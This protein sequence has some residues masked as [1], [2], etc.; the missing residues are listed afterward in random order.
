MVVD[1]A[2]WVG[3]YAFR[4]LGELATPEWLLRQMDRLGIDRAWVG[5]L[6]AAVTRDPRPA[7]AALQRTLSPHAD[8]LVMIP[9]VHPGQARWQ[10]DVRR[11]TDLGAPAIRLYP[12]YLEL[13]A[14]GAEMRACV[15]AAATAKL[16]VQLTVRLEDM[17][18]RH[19]PDPGT[20]LSAAAVRRLVRAVS[21]SR[22]LVTHATRE[23]VEEVHFGLTPDEADRVLWEASWIWGPPE[24]H[25]ALLLE[26][27][28]L[29]RF[30]FGTG[31]P[32]RIPDAAMAKVDLLDVDDRT[33]QR[34]LTG[35]LREWQRFP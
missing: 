14:A 12:Q 26:T 3:E 24:D 29:E 20:E 10:D 19:A 16:P 32:L 18:Q 21:G 9:T 7:D 28:G 22:M 2:C 25:L 1:V 5:S 6:P 31:M 34:L 23:F 17:R 33:R 30:A 8:R 35:N 11:A 27:V 13:D 15:T 4:H